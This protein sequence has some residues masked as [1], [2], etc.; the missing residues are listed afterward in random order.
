MKRHLRVN[1]IVMHH[2]W[3]ILSFN[4]YKLRAFL[5]CTDF[6]D[7]LIIYF[8]VYQSILQYYGMLVWAMGEV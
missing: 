4:F 3:C 5:T 1:S 8:A 7:L 6:A 2:R